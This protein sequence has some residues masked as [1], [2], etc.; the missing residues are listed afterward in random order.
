MRYDGRRYDFRRAAVMALSPAADG[1]EPIVR[2][3]QR[4][5][6]LPATDPAE[7]A[8]ALHRA[9]VQSRLPTAPA[10][11]E[12]TKRQQRA[13]RANEGWREFVAVY[14]RFVREWVLPQFGG[15]DLLY[16]AQPVLRVVLPG[17]VPPCRPHCDSDYYH[18]ANELNF[19]CPLNHVF[20]A[21]SLWAESSPGAADFAPLEAAYGCAVRFY[22]NRCRHFTVDNTGGAARC[23]FDFRVVP[24]H[25]FRAGTAHLGAEGAAHLRG[26]EGSGRLGDGGYYKL[27]RAAGGPPRALGEGGAPTA[28][29][30]KESGTASCKRCGLVRP[31]ASFADR[32]WRKQRPCCAECQQRLEREDPRLRAPSDS[33]ESAGS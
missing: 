31:R 8:P 2:L 12:A 6:S 4:Q 13:W 20:G 16:Q 11:K 27:A 29:S 15:A 1:A 19:W 32:Q 26:T 25:L 33:R 21:S 23:S 7:T 24:A 22:G 18:D 5:R 14:E 28:E 9:R 10:S 17:S 30:G 3:L